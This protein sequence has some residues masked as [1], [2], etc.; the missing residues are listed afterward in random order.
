MPLAANQPLCLPSLPN[1]KT[2]YSLSQ[3]PDAV[4]ARSLVRPTVPWPHS[5]LSFLK[6]CP[7]RCLLP[8]RGVYPRICVGKLQ[9]HK[10]LEQRWTPE[11]NT[12][13]PGTASSEPL[14]P[15]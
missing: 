3:P 6:Q 2:T 10:M 12:E 15:S 11:G 7:G 5:A 14:L 1:F 8:E 9:N 13:G 4:L